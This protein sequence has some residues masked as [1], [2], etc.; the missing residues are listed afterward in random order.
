MCVCE[1]VDVQG[2]DTD[3]QEAHSVKNY[4]DCIACIQSA[5]ADLLCL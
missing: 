2:G 1:C 4:A 5:I 3:G